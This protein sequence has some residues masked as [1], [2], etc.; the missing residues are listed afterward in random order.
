M[1]TRVAEI[2]LAAGFLLLLTGGSVWAQTAAAV[3][4][5]TLSGKIT[6]PSQA[7]LPGA[8][9]SLKQSGMGQP[10]E[11]QSD[12]AG[13]YTFAGIAAGDYEISVVAQGFE[14]K[15]TQV[16]L[17]AGAKQEIDFELAPLPDQAEPGA[18]G[19]TANQQPNAPAPAQKEP[20]LQ[21]LGFPNAQTQ[22]NAKEQA[23]LDK[24]THM[25]K[26]HQRLGLITTIPLAAAIISSAG[27]GGRSTSSTSRDA[28]AALGSA[29]AGFYIATAYFAIRAPR[30]AGTETRGPIKWHKALAWVHGP[31]MILTPI[32]GAIAFEQKSRG[33]RVHGIASAHLPVALVTAG[34]FGAALVS[35]SVKF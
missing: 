27:A 17:T 16:N 2:V 18:N 7:A 32:L 29:A 13:V 23:L 25:L 15:S 22:G 4:S 3:E 21:E 30:I 6:G 19:Q 11:M 5:V 31:G 20:S 26:I 14:T 1:K 35:V 10:I 33:E 9:V 8:T 12:A 34:A 28:H 24:R